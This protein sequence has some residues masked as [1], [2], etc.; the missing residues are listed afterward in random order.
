MDSELNEKYI[1]PAVFD[2]RCAKV[3]AEEVVI[4][5]EYLNLEQNKGKREW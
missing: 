3:I 4:V 1:I 5:A 2:K